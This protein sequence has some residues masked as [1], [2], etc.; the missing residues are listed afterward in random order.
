MIWGGDD[1]RIDSVEIQY[2]D[3]TFK[4][5]LLPVWLCAYRFQNKPFQVM[6]NAQT[7]EVLGDR[8][9]SFLKILL[10]VFMVALLTVG[11]FWLLIQEQGTDQLL[12]HPEIN[13]SSQINPPSDIIPFPGSSQPSEASLPISNQPQVN[14]IPETNE[15]LISDDL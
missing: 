12:Q 2:H 10:T 1:Q 5:L 11:G 14:S 7:G 4:H 6:I 13:Q 9:Y 8:P 3:R 15:R